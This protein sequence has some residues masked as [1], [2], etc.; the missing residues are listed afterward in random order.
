M[1]YH[2]AKRKHFCW[3]MR[4]DRTNFPVGVAYQNTGFAS[5]LPPAIT[6]STRDTVMSFKPAP[7]FLCEFFQHVDVNPQ[8]SSDILPPL[9]CEVKQGMDRDNSTV[10][11]SYS[12]QNLGKFKEMSKNA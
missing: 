3:N 6:F 4:Q 12:M 10:K 9:T 1:I 11:T 2:M 8:R 7:S 5:F